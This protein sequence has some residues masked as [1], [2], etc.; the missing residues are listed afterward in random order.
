MK[1]KLVL[2]MAI[3]LTVVISCMTLMGCV[4]SRPDEYLVEFIKASSKALVV[5]YKDINEVTAVSKDS[6]YVKEGTQEQ[7]FI[8]G[9][10]NVKNYILKDDIWSYVSIPVTQWEKTKYAE[11]YNL[12]SD[13]E[14]MISLLETRMGVKLEEMTNGFEENYEQDDKGWWSPKKI[15]INIKIKIKVVKGELV[16]RST[17]NGE[18]MVTKYIINY[19]IKVPKDAKDAE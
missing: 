10:D 19:K 3:A 16:V 12:A 17:V 13:S 7:Y 15:N 18:T 5:E 11:K 4:P 6:M 1:K 14:K 9:E 2:L 8:I